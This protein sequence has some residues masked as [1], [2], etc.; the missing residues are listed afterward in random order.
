MLMSFTVNT[1]NSAAPDLGAAGYRENIYD[2]SDNKTSPPAVIQKFSILHSALSINLRCLFGIRYHHN[3][4]F[5]YLGGAG[6]D[7]ALLA[8]LYHH[9]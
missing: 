4:A 6:G 9:D 5:K 8:A 7:N 1:F 2:P 3:I